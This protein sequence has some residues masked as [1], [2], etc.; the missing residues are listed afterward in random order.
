MTWEATEF[1]RGDYRVR[2]EYVAAMTAWLWVTY[3]CDEQI[4]TF[5]DPKKAKRWCSEHRETEMKN[6]EA[7]AQQREGK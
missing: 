4:G 7:H 1:E 6:C 5:S 3:Y 2:R